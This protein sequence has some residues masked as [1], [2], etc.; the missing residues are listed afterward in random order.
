MTLRIILPVLFLCPTLGL[1]GTPIQTELTCPIGGE[2]FEITETTSCTEYPG[3]TMSFSPISSCDFVTRLPQCPQNFLP[4][5]RSFSDEDIT[6]LSEFMVSETY[7]SMIDSSR[8]YMAYIIERQLGSE[9]PSTPFSL[10]LQGLW[11]DPENTFSDAAYIAE[12]LAISRSEIERE[13]V[14]NRPYLQSIA[15]F[16]EMKAGNFDAAEALIQTAAAENI[17]FLRAYHRAIEAC[18]SDQSSEYCKPESLIPAP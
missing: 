9:D 5:Y 11:F 10:L 1:A 12:F 7:D 4:V 8:F 16:V 6:F 18:M 15:A 14:E 17:P 2:R 13:T 3:R